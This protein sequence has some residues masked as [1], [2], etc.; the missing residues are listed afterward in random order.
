MDLKY[1]VELE[2]EQQLKASFPNAGDEEKIRAKIGSDIGVNKLGINAHRKGAEIYYSVPI[3]V[4]V[5]R[6]RV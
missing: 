6:R 2:L 4:F 1:E 5:G 3:A